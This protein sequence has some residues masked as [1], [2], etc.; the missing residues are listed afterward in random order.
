MDTETTLAHNHSETS[1]MAAEEQDADKVA[2]DRNRLMQ[3]TRAS[4]A[5]L[6]REEM[7][8]RTGILPN[9]VNPRVNELIRSG[10][11]VPNG[12]EKNANGRLVEVL[13]IPAGQSGEIVSVTTDWKNRYYEDDHW[14]RTRDARMVFDSYICCWCHQSRM[15]AT[16]EVHHSKYDLFNEAMEDLMTLCTDCHVRIHEGA[17][18]RFPKVVSREIYERLQPPPLPV[19]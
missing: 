5:G 16:L 11:L 19:L 6:T 1:R 2:R 10:L 7:S 17:H 14:A 12:R 15:S 9:T 18:L 8:L 4:S 3:A 13:T